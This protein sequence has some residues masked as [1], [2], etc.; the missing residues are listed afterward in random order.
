L[1][2]LVVVIGEHSSLLT[3]IWTTCTIDTTS[4]LSHYLYKQSH[5]H[6]KDAEHQINPARNCCRDTGNDCKKMAVTM[7]KNDIA[8]YV[9]IPTGVVNRVQGP[10]CVLCVAANIHAV[11][12]LLSGAAKASPALLNC[13]DIVLHVHSLIKAGS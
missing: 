8:I 6:S 13:T 3:L 2:L 11:L 10:F 4:H 9:A 1:L 12:R 7:H 5:Y